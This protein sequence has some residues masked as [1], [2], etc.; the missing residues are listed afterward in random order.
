V[1]GAL[2]VATSD[3]LQKLTKSLTKLSKRVDDLAKRQS[4]T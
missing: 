1:L 4:T 2:G 3:D